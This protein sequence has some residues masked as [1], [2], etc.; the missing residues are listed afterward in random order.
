MNIIGMI[1]IILA[2]VFFLMAVLHGF[3]ILV[4]GVKMFG[5]VLPR[6][7]LLSSDFFYNPFNLYFKPK[8]LDEEGLKEREKSIGSIIKMMVFMLLFVLAIGAGQA[9]IN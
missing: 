2:I 3:L 4:Y 9:M 5:H 1:L 6:I 8:F 7:K